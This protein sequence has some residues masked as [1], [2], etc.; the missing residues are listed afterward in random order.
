M[1]IYSS[2]ESFY[3]DNIHLPHDHDHVLP[4]F[5][6]YTKFYLFF[7]DALDAIDG[8]YISCNS[9]AEDQQVVCNHNGSLTQN[10]LAI[11]SFNMSFC[12]YLVVGEAPSDSTI[13]EDA[14]ITDLPILHGKYYLADSGFP[15]FEL[16]IVFC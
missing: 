5:L 2:S 14:H 4:E 12:I 7:K 11:C 6:D 3:V 16:L 1:L 13:F 9:T 15:I 10:C 8:K